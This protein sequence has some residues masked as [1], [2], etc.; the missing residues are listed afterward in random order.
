MN[1]LIKDCV[2][3]FN[4]CGFSYSICGGYA[5]ELFANMHIRPHSDIDIWISDTDKEKSIQSICL[6]K[7]GIY[8]SPWVIIYY[9]LLSTLTS[10]I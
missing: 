8:M 2:N 4:D 6:I 7:D 10:N 5:L 1:K 3:F 9:D